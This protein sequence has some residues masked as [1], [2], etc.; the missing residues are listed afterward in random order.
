LGITKRGN[1]YLRK[2]LIQSARSAMPSLVKSDTATGVWLR[3][4]LARAHPN[5]AV[6]AFGRE[7]GAHRLCAA[8]PRTDLS[9]RVDNGMRNKRPADT[10]SDAANCER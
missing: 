1:K 8:P 5:V 7:D 2:M 9:G 10:S 6:V 3:A 4:L